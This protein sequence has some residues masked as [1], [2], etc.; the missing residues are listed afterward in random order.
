MLHRGVPENQYKLSTLRPIVF[1]PTPESYLRA[2]WGSC[3]IGSYLEGAHSDRCA[4]LDILPPPL[5]AR[6]SFESNQRSLRLASS[7]GPEMRALA[8]RLGYWI[9]HRMA[10][11]SRCRRPALPRQ[12][13]ASLAQEQPRLR[14]DAVTIPLSAMVLA[15]KDLKCA[16]RR[17]NYTWTHRTASAQNFDGPSDEYRSEGVR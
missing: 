12:P 13:P 10:F 9:L 8:P 16:P 14:P 1:R 4:D 17:S 7:Q 5:P 3:I 2:G 11:A 15:M 6:R